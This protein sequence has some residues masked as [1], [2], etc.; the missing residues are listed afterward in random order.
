MKRLFQPVAHKSL[1]SNV[2]GYSFLEL[3]VGATLASLTLSLAFSVVFS[4]R[5]LYV[6]DNA[7]INTNQN[8]RTAI[9]L[10]GADVRQTG[11]FITDRN[12]PVIVLTDDPVN[13]D[14]LTIR[15]G[16]EETL[17]PV[18]LDVV[19]GVTDIA[20]ALPNPAIAAC[21]RVAREADASGVWP[22][23]IFTWQTIRQ[24][25]NGN[26][27]NAFI[28]D[29]DNSPSDGEF[30]VYTD[31]RRTPA[32]AP[33]TPDSLSTY[34]LTS[35]NGTWL[36]SYSPDGANLPTLALLEQRRFWLDENGNLVLDF[37]DVDGNV[38]NQF[39][40]S[41]VTEFQVQLT[42]QDGT[43]RTTFNP[44]DDWSQIASVDITLSGSSAFNATDSID[45]TITSSFLPRN[46]LSFRLNN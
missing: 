15:R 25:A 11:E 18:C 23:N 14:T 46:V 9:D 43:V 3:V 4:N 8:I 17:L 31:E 2:R 44:G 20:I 45:Q 27:I 22:D 33:V 16:L 12:F 39:V 6:R 30:F 13:G 21:S 24:D 37:V 28:F 5:N 35:N 7:R 34:A 32:E 38:N 29:E 26:S 40:V 19:D 42:M 41:D 36:N 1:H 10:I